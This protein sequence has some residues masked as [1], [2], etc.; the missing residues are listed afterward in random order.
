MTINPVFHSYNKHIELGYHFVLERVALGLL[1]THY[2]PTNDQVVDLFTK[3]LSKA[4]LMHF[5]TKLC[6]QPW[7]RLREGISNIVLLSLDRNYGTY[8]TYQEIQS[9]SKY[10]YENPYNSANISGDPLKK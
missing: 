5:K 4:A 10:E 1:V 7:P 9:Y 6:L 3:L 8:L 2:I